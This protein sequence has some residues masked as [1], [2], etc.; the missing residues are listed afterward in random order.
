MNKREASSWNNSEQGKR[1]GKSLWGRKTL[2]YLFQVSVGKPCVHFSAVV[3]RR[4]G[5]WLVALEGTGELHAR[6]ALPTAAPAPSPKVSQQEKWQLSRS[7]FCLNI[8]GWR[9]TW[10]WSLCLFHT[11]FFVSLGSGSQTS[12]PSPGSQPRISLQALIPSLW[13]LSREVSLVSLTFMSQK[14]GNNSWEQM[15]NAITTE[16]SAWGRSGNILAWHF[17]LMFTEAL[18]KIRWN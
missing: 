2:P 13:I 11:T 7:Q 6:L 14:G 17:A 3:C 15:G 16:R 4:V 12:I 9:Q 8:P 1:R 10:R 5:K 18:W